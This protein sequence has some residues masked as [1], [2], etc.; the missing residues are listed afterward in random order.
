MKN[1][2]TVCANVAA[3]AAQRVPFGKCD[4]AVGNPLVTVIEEDLAVATSHVAVVAEHTFEGEP[5]RLLRPCGPSQPPSLQKAGNFPR[6][7]NTH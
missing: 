5:P 4:L 3:V 1:D 2:I 7:L 6:T